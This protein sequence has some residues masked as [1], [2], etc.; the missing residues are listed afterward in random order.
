MTKI[1]AKNKNEIAETEVKKMF[2]TVLWYS[3]LHGYIRSIS[4]SF[5]FFD[6][7]EWVDYG[8]DHNENKCPE[9][10]V[11]D[12]GTTDPG[13]LV[14]SI[15]AFMHNENEETVTWSV[16]RNAGVKQVASFLVGIASFN[17]PL[18][19]RATVAKL[20]IQIVTDE[21]NQKH[22]SASKISGIQPK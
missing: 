13:I 5:E 11:G 16:F 3:K 20:T 17:I 2:E 19:R 9:E 12:T 14:V 21:R 22:G 18:E 10:W 4:D 15:G 1:M 8:N 7:E 6:P